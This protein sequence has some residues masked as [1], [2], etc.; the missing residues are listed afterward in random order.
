MFSKAC[1]K[2]V[3]QNFASTFSAGQGKKNPQH[4][5]SYHIYFCISV[6]SLASPHTDCFFHSAFLKENCHQRKSFSLHFLTF[7][8][9][10]F[11]L[12]YNSW[13]TMAEK[14]EIQR[15]NTNLLKGLSR[16]IQTKSELVCSPT[17]MQFGILVSFMLILLFFFKPTVSYTSNLTIV[18]RLYL[19]LLRLPRQSRQ[20]RWALPRFHL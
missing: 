16:F 4:C 11:N 5:H 15:S 20:N 14:T 12:A 17:W 10:P 13:W 8:D 3:H 19:L 18:E 1:F 6:W 2:H 9:T 7:Q